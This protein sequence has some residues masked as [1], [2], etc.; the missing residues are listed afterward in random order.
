MPA[1]QLPPPS[2]DE[3]EEDDEDDEDDE[4][5]DRERP[6]EPPLPSDTRARRFL[7]SPVSAPMVTNAATATTKMMPIPM[8]SP[9]F[10]SPEAAPRGPP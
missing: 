10:R 5:D 6:R 9:S 7:D 1:H 3:A 2:Y 4:R 8:A